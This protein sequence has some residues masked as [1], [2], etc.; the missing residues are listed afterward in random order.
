MGSGDKPTRAQR[1]QFW[2]TTPP[3]RPGDINPGL[4]AFGGSLLHLHFADAQYVYGVVVAGDLMEELRL[5]AGNEVEAWVNSSVAP[6]LALERDAVGAGNRLIVL[7]GGSRREVF[8]YEPLPETRM[9]RVAQ[10]IEFYYFPPTW[11]IDS[12]EAADR[13]IDFEA[14]RARVY[15]RQLTQS[16][17]KVAAARDGLFTFDFSEWS[18]GNIAPFEGRNPFD[19]SKDLRELRQSLWVSVANTFQSCLYANS[20]VHATPLASPM[21]LTPERLH[22]GHSLDSGCGGLIRAHFGLEEARYPS[23]YDKQLPPGMDWKIKERSVRGPAL[24][25]AA[26]D[27]TLD[28]LD[29]LLALPVERG[30]HRVEMYGLAARAFSDGNFSMALLQGWLVT[31]S[32]L[33]EMWAEHL[34]GRNKTFDDGSKLLGER[35]LSFLTDKEVTISLCSHLLLALEVLPLRLFQKTEKGRKARNELVH[36]MKTPKKAV[37]QELLEATRELLSQ[38]MGVEWTLPL[39]VYAHWSATPA[40]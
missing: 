6:Q 14:M 13:S 16:R 26:L 34:E 5:G 20:L 17:I 30:L 1:K 36:S 7:R 40:D 33:S 23:S 35:R 39:T 27:A 18:E 31:E 12:P 11:V 3:F 4:D 8:P 10:S 38:R 32:L 37:V 28:E 25:K 22:K 15:Q 2:T 9:W 29:M 24:S 21:P 19:G